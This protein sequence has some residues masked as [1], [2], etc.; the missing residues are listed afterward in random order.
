MI[1]VNDQVNFIVPVAPFEPK[2][3]IERSVK[4][5]QGTEI[6]ES[7]EKKIFYVIDT[8]QDPTEDE[9]VQYLRQETSGEVNTIVRT[10]NEGR[11]AGAINRALEEMSIPDYV[12][13]F[14][15]DS[16]PGEKFVEACI[17]QLEDEEKFFMATCPRKIINGNRNFVTKMVE[18]EYNYLTDMQL[19]MD[20]TGSFNHFNGLISVI[21]G[22]YLEKEKLN[23]S[24]M[25][26]DTDFSQR[27]YLSGRRPTINT[28]SY[29]GEQAVTSISDLY[30]QQVRWMNGALEGLTHFSGPFLRSNLPIKVKLSWLSVMVLP[31]FAAVLSPLAIIHT[32]KNIFT[33]GDV[34][35]SMEKG[36]AL[37]CFAWFV[38]YCGVVNLF[39]LVFGGDVKWTDSER[40]II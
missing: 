33:T 17:N 4:A 29:L 24:R 9:R 12:A 26:E 5:L 6:P 31:F 30:S 36:F 16:R 21:D 34:L 2:E 38:S 39:K 27:A 19:L 13:I 37:F 18:A 1:N 23:E 28:E 22:D 20:R 32:I 40:E 7:F 3:I 15:I 14:D 35:K 25:C 11:R 10:S 8:D